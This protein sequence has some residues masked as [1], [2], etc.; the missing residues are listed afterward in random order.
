MVYGMEEGMVQGMVKG[1]VEGM[2]QEMVEGIFLPF[3]PSLSL[4]LVPSPSFPSSHSFCCPS[5]SPSLL[6]PPPFTLNS[7]QTSILLRYHMQSLAHLP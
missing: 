6:S 1:I 5:L 4:Y 7:R 3:T 2:V